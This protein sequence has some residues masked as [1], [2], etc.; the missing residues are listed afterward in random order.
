MRR[1]NSLWRDYRL[2]CLNGRSRP[3]PRAAICRVSRSAH[4]FR[5][6][7][8][9]HA[10]ASLAD[11]EAA[12]DRAEQV[13]G[14]ERAGDLAE[15]R[16]AEPQAPRRTTRARGC[17]AS[18]C[19]AARSRWARVRCKAC[20][21]R[22]RAMKRSSGAAC[23]PANSSRRRRSVSRPWPVN[24]ET[25]RPSSIDALR[26]R[27]D[28][29]ED[30]QE[31]PVGA[32]PRRQARSRSPPR[33][34]RSRSRRPRQVV[35]E[36]DRVG[37]LDLGPAARDAD[38]LDFV[39]AFAQAGGVDDVDRHALDLD[40][41]ADLVARRAG[42][43]RDDRQLGAGERVEE[44]ALAD[45]R[46]AGEDDLDAVAQQGALARARE[47][48]VDALRAAA[49]GGRSRRRL[50]GNRFPRPESRASPR[51]GG[52]ARSSV[53]ASASISF[54]NAPSSERAAERAAASVL[55]SIKSATASACARSSLSLRKARSVN[56]PGRAMRKP[57]SSGAP[58]LGSSAAP[59]SRQRASS[60]CSTTGPPCACSSSTSSPVYECG[61]GK[62]SAR[63][64]SI[65][66][67]AASR[68][69]R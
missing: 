10:R 68:N 60:S 38:A 64:W 11:A 53:A 31:A 12:E 15:R 59:A 14:A 25:T 48:R 49:P 62:K 33:R 30:V 32:E 46:L 21:W 63:P 23:Q 47:Y 20:T 8:G 66:A 43:R 9:P 67:P 54:E 61:A 4:R 16:V 41:L 17:P 36:D 5:A 1:G 42:R 39:G 27:I 55:A 6:A 34:R 40:R 3:A 26:P 22:A 37:A 28:L 50:R 29:V 7:G 44:R 45:V 24:A 19:A 58:V 65:G 69:G 18:A 56:S 57:A 2:R 52:A 51:P 13:V 35:Q